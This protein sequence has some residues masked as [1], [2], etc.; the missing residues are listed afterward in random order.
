MHPHE[1][2]A[3]QQLTPLESSHAMVEIAIQSVAGDDVALAKVWMLVNDGGLNGDREITAEG[4]ARRHPD[5]KPNPY[6]AEQMALGRA[7]QK[8]GKQLERRSFG[9]VKHADDV[10]AHR[11][12]LLAERQALR[13]KSTKRRGLISRLRQKKAT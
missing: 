8:A 10:R 13:R 12:R 7:L 6:V 3:A 5:D 9:L 2:D 1:F 4:R 11:R